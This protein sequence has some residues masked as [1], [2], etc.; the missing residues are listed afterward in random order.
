MKIVHVC[1]CGPYTDDY[2][3]QENL[4]AKYHKKMGNEVTVIASEWMWN[5]KGEIVK[6]DKNRYTDSRGIN[7]IRLPIKMGNLSNRLRRYRGFKDVLEE[8][9]PELLFVHDMQFLDVSVI[10][11]YVKNNKETVLFFDNHCDEKNSASNFISKN[12]LHKIIWKHYINKVAPYVKKFYGVLPARV[13]FMKKMYNIADDKCEL[14][15][16]GADDELVEKAKNNGSGKSLREKYGIKDDDYLLCTGGKINKNRSETLDLM[17]VISK[18]DKKNI[19]LLIFGTVSSEYKDV[20]DELCKDEKIIFVGWKT[21]EETYDIIEAADIVIFPGL[22]S[23][24]WEQAV[25]QGRVCILRDI[26]GFHHVDFGG[27]VVFINASSENDYGKPI[28][29]II[30]DLSVFKKMDSIAKSDNRKKF[31]YSSIAQKIIDDYYE[32][33]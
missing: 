13:D 19:K 29:G 17:K 6:C 24:L 9:K 20:F 8:L 15:C 10:T 21:V 1:L 16:M 26:E 32:S 11:G 3:Y 4:L 30:D 2:G 12:V 5:T 18:S 33:K 22:H 27:N 25:G 28:F 31:L 14:L 7:V 23:V